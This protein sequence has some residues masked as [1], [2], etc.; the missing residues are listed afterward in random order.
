MANRLFDFLQTKVFQKTFSPCPQ[1]DLKYSF[2]IQ[3]T[4]S[5]ASSLPSLLHPCSFSLAISVD[6]H[7]IIVG[8]RRGPPQF[9][10]SGARWSLSRHRRQSHTSISLSRFSPT[11]TGSPWETDAGHLDFSFPA[12]VAPSLVAAK[13]PICSLSL[14][15]HS[16]ESSLMSLVLLYVCI[17]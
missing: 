12:P 2:S 4:F 13:V 6:N 14:S 17:S 16:S 9:L 1:K 10:T 5:N 7:R 8:F 15:R 3:Q 11:V